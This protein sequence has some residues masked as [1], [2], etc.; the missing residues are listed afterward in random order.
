MARRAAGL[1]A[2][3]KARKAA[4]RAVRG[5][6]RTTV[7]ISRLNASVGFPYRRP[8]VPRG[9]VVPPSKPTLGADYETDWARRRPARVARSII[10]NGPLRLAVRTL[11]APEIR[12]IDR[13]AD[14][15]AL[16]TSKK[17]TSRR[18]GTR[19]PS[20]SRPTTT[21]TSTRRWPSP[22]S[23]SRGADHLVVGAAADYFFT[24]PRH[25]RGLGAGPQRVPGR[26]QRRRPA[27]RRTWPGS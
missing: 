15:R 9:V 11:A 2:P 19:R 25:E 17:G 21:A 22:P 12:G 26:P 13:L 4:D 5:V 1:P 7:K 3:L 8:T 20:S 10:I 16:D 6:R 18:A 27:D 14:L 24:T 23:P